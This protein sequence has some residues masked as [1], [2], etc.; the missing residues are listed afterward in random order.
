VLK[1]QGLV[2]LYTKG[3]VGVS[4]SLLVYDYDFGWAGLRRHFEHRGAYTGQDILRNLIADALLRSL[5]L[6]LKSALSLRLYPANLSQLSPRQQAFR[7]VINIL[8]TSVAKGAFSSISRP[9]FHGER[10][11]GPIDEFK[12]LL[13]FDARILRITLQKVV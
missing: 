10:W 11:T 5:P 13:H 1:P 12:F 2:D 3:G 4:S 6:F 8:P 7:A 9:V